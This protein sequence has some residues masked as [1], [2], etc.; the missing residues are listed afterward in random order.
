MPHGRHLYARSY[1]MEN[2]TMCTYPQS[3]HTLPH[4]KCVLQCCANC[5]CINITEQETDNQYSETTSSITFQINHIIARF[6]DHVMIPLKD[7][8]TCY[9]CKQ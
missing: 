4:W 5:P 9:M 1:D 2:S 8:K 6:T 7:K 3:A